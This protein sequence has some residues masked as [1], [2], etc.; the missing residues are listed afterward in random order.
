MNKRKDEMGNVDIDE[1]T[2]EIIE[3]VIEDKLNGENDQV[4]LL[5][6]TGEQWSQREDEPLNWYDRFSSYYLP[7]GIHNRSVAKAYRLYTG[8]DRPQA[9]PDWY[10]ISREWEWEDRA[11]AYD[12]AKLELR[13]DMLEGIEKDIEEELKGAL[14]TGLRAAVHRIDKISTGPESDMDVKTAM[15]A[16]PRF[17]KELQNIF[18]VGSKAGAN[19]AIEDFL[20]A[21]PSG[22]AQRVMILI[23]NKQQQQLPHIAR[24][25]GNGDDDDSIIDGVMKEIAKP[26]SALPDRSGDKNT[27]HI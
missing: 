23:E 10:R 12:H 3:G 16:I 1:V 22:M 8:M 14:L 7:L 15:S 9:P 27:S 11:A 26:T 5:R 18:E 19:H 6:K 21:L 24:N 17:T 13:Q 2:G 25:Q 20:K 4:V